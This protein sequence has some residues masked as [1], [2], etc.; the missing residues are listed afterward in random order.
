LAYPVAEVTIAGNLA[1]MLSNIEAVGNDL[2]FR[3]S[4]GSPT[5]LIREMTVSGEKQSR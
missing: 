3:G 1:K 5:L 2:E 4:V